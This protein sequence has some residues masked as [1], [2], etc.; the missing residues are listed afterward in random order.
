M[1][2][3][4][5]ILTAMLLAGLAGLEGCEEKVS[6]QRAD[7]EQTRLKA[8][9]DELARQLDESRAR[10]ADLENRRADLI[11]EL[12][13]ARE[14]AIQARQ[15]SVVQSQLDK[16]TRDYSRLKADYDSLA[17]ENRLVKQSEMRLRELNQSVLRRMSAPPASAPDSIRIN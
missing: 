11:R 17:E 14:E 8:A 2:M 12:D 16:A 9:N 5:V 6:K 1:T 4:G 15:L 13:A 3:R 7:S 10:A